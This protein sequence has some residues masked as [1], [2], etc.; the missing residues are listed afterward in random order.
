VLRFGLR[1]IDYE[2][3]RTG[4]LGTAAFLAGGCIAARVSKREQAI[5]IRRDDTDWRV[6][7]NSQTEADTG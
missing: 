3:L 7:P 5:V 6:E 1:G 2:W 4:R